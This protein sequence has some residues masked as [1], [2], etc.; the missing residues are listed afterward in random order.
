MPSVDHPT[1]PYYVMLLKDS[2][3]SYK[4][5]KTFEHH[6]IEDVIY[7]KG[8]KEEEY[9]IGVIGTGL[10]GKGVVEVAVKTGNRIIFK[11]RSEKSLEKAIETISKSLSK[12]MEP[13]ELEATLGRIT[14]TTRYEPLANA[15]LIIESVIENLQTK[16]KIFQKLDSIC[17]PSVILASNTSSLSVSKIAEGIKHPERAVG[18]H[19]FNPIPKMKLVEIIKAEKTS[20]DAV[21][22]AHEFAAKFNKVSVDVKDTAGFIVNRLLFI[23]INEA[24]RMLDEGVANVKDI[25][26]AMKLGANHPMGPLELS[27]LIGLDLC[28]EIIENLNTSFGEKFEPSSTLR[29]FVKEG[30]YGRKAGRGF[31]EY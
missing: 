10:T 17:N 13:E 16:K 14:A 8:K 3:G 23:M 9:T 31:Y 26:K 6:N 27:D 28:L 15:S 29:N 19:F 18:M 1:T 12:G 22:K 21:K 11:S 25:D 24:C 2:N 7:V 5:Q 20:D 4:F 30:H